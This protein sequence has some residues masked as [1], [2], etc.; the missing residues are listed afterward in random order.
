MAYYKEKIGAAWI[1]ALVVLVYFFTIILI[2]AIRTLMIK[3]NGKV[4]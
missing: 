1:I 4:L 3:G 2:S